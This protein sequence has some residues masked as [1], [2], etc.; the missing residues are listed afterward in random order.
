MGHRHSRLRCFSLQDT[1]EA[2]HLHIS[3]KPA[4]VCTLT[5]NQEVKIGKTFPN[6]DLL[7]GD[8]IPKVER[9]ASPLRGITSSLDYLAW[10][11]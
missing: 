7:Q 8:K 5:N 4:V 2:S 1:G 10:I 6:Q 3:P 11:A 9:V